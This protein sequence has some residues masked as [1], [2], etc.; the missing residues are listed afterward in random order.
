LARIEI[1]QLKLLINMMLIQP[2]QLGLKIIMDKTNIPE[3]I[4]LE[5][6]IAKLTYYSLW[7]KISSLEMLEEC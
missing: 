3:I 4:L 2:F 5:Q 6:N 7:N 1:H